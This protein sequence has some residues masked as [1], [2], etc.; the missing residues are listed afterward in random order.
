MSF[1]S[2]WGYLVTVFFLVAAFIAG[3]VGVAYHLT[4]ES[5]SVLLFLFW[6][7]LCAGFGRKLDRPEKPSALF[8]IRIEYWGY[9]FIVLAV[10]DAILNWNNITRDWFASA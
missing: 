3:G 7:L 4:R 6:G 2:R 1:F 8:G 9:G 10:I 5:T